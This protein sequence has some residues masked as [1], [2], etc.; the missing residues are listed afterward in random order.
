[1][2]KKYHV[3]APYTGPA[4]AGVTHVRL[5]S[6]D[7]EAE[8]RAWLAGF[9]TGAPLAARGYQVEAEAPAPDSTPPTL[10]SR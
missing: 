7:T 4:F 3:Q 10:R 5:F 2:T 8:A 9:M 6:A 1:M